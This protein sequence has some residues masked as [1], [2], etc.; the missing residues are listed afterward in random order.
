MQIFDV[1]KEIWDFGRRYMPGETMKAEP[2]DV[3]WLVAQ[4]KIAPQGAEPAAGDVEP[5]GRRRQNKK[6]APDTPA[7]NEGDGK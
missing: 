3:R 4:G 7:A 6:T 2:H 1:K 5:K